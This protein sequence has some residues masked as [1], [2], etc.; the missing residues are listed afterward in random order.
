MKK[1]ALILCSGGIDST[2]TAH[3]VSKRKLYSR[4]TILF[5]DYGQ[6][7]RLLERR[8]ARACAKKLSMNFVE[9]KLP[10]LGALSTSLINCSGPSRSVSQRDL[11]NLDNEHSA[12]YVPCRN[13]IFLSYAL[14]YAEKRF[15]VRK[16]KS[17]IFVGFKCEGKNSYPDTTEPYVT[18]MNRLAKE[19]CAYPFSIKAPFIRSDK[20][21]I[22]SSGQK[23]GVDFTQTISCYRPSSRSCGRC[24]ACSLRHAGFYWAGIED[25]TS[26][27]HEPT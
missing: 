8:C 10:E 9:M 4:H 14:A 17:D 12:W 16:E 26:Y 18:L 5:F 24:M 2:V 19:S 27:Q 3:Y 11:K 15:L 13:T 6:H 22:I 7:A 25:P 23:L 20:E 21:D 1:H